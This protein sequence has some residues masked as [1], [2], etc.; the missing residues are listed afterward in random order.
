VISA[1]A[2]NEDESEGHSGLVAF[3]GDLLLRGRR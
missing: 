1:E 3:L 2:A